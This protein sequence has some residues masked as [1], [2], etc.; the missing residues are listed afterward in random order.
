M[1]L[2]RARLA[3]LR[4]KRTAITGLSLVLMVGGVLLDMSLNMIFG[5]LFPLS[6]AAAATMWIG[7]RYITDAIEHQTQKWRLQ[8]IMDAIDSVAGWLVFL[9]EQQTLLN[10][11]RVSVDKPAVQLMRTIP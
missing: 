9:R 11:L 6:L 1:N 2:E 8:I 10:T 5:A 4:W 7:D 3:G